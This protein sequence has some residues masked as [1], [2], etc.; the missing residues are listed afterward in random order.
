VVKSICLIIAL[1]LL[2]AHEGRV[3][4]AK[5]NCLQARAGTCSLFNFLGDS[6]GTVY[7]GGG[8]SGL[9]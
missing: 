3:I 8:S 6:S 2:L 1:L 9:A 7:V 4:G 5:G